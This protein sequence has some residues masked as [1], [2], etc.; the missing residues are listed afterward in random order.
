VRGAESRP[1]GFVRDLCVALA[2]R[3]EPEGLFVI[4]TA[5]FDESG[6]HGDSPVTVMAGIMAN[7]RQWSVFQSG[8]DKIRSRYGFRVFH[9][10]KFKNGSGEFAGWS[11]EKS[12]AMLA[13]LTALSSQTVMEAV[14]FPLSNADYDSQYRERGKPNKARLDTKYGLCFRFC[15]VHLVSEAI[16]RLGTHK[17]FDQT[18][19]HV[20]VESG[21]RH[22]GDAARVFDE[23]RL[24]FHNL[25]CDLLKTITF[26][27]KECDPLMIANFIS[28]T[29][30]MNSIKREGL[31]DALALRR[32]QGVPVDHSRRHGA[33]SA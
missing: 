28:H 11:A 9:A 7:A 6:T 16:R 27:G 10:T 33:G 8:L 22:A 23:E 1:A 18:S 24:E 4:L 19:L 20:V 21:H 29:T 12:L 17:K 13:E 15:L 2:H 30:H 25:G 5:Y 32:S 14:T 26:A 3:W 31:C